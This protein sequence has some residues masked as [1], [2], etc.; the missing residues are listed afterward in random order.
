MIERLELKNFRNFKHLVLEPGRRLALTGRNGRG[1]STVVDA[2]AWAIT[3]QCRGVNAKGEG[4]QDLIRTGAEEAE[5]ILDDDRLGQLRRTITRGGSA[6]SNIPT[7]MI[8]NRLGVTKGAAGAA[9]YG[10]QFFEMDYKDAQ[11]MLMQLLD[12]RIPAE[13]LPGVRLPKNATDAT[14]DEVEVFYQAAFSDRAAQKKVL[15]S[16]TVPVFTRSKQLDAL[17]LSDLKAAAV[18]ADA[19][20]TKAVKALATAEAN[21][22][23][24]QGQADQIT[25]G[26]AGLD[27]LKGALAAHQGMLEEHA[28]QQVEHQRA[29]GQLEVVANGVSSAQDLRGR[30]ATMVAMADRISQ[31]SAT[32][33][34]V[35]S[36]SIPCMTKAEAFAGHVRQIGVDVKALELELVDAIETAEQIAAMRQKLAEA[37]QNVNYHQHQVDRHNG[38]I[39]AAESAQGG[40]DDIQAKIADTKKKLPKLKADLEK[41]KTER[42]QADVAAVDL[43]N[44]QGACEAAQKAAAVKDEGQAE[45]ARL[46]KLV[47]LLGPKGVRA[48]ALAQAVEGFEGLVNAG[49][50]DFG[51]Q[52]SIQ[53]QPW[54]IYVKTPATGGIA[55]RFD[56]LSDGQKLWTGAAFQLALAKQSGFGICA[57]DSV[58]SVVDE[59]RAALAGLI[60]DAD[61]D[62]VLIGIA[63]ADDE[64]DPQMDGLKV[65]RLTT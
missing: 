20:Y 6:T 3:G 21:L 32:S 16:L 18:K 48:A 1:K 30:M 44:Y 11:R 54:A 28:N 40:L 19:A 45:L 61:V 60:M 55:V 7:D 57:V 43:A 65:V 17:V 13:Q 53:V 4:Q 23:T 5:V 22:K 26:K 8:L 10:R 59:D 27:Q 46:E 42:D 29:L 31:H 12:V 41:L 63:K 38:L 37:V 58:E 50:A 33:G 62:Q 47:E 35:L 51:C 14:L 34:C 64:E 2:I 56:L 9:L 49:L 39:L 15:A 52:L 24:W 25:T 36:S